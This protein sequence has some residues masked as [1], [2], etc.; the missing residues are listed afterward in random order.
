MENQ[1]V[2]SHPLTFEDLTNIA[3]DAIEAAESIILGDSVA[4][5][6]SWCVKRITKVLETFDN[7]IP[8]IGAILENPIA[9][10]LEENAVKFLVDWAWQLFGK[11]QQ[12]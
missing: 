11:S 6:K 7:Y 4:E 3:K 2:N 5:K 12:Q 8:V 9:D 1:D 10:D